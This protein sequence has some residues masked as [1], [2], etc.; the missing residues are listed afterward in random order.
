MD[1]IR[2]PISGCLDI[3]GYGG[4]EEADTLAKDGPVKTP[5]AR[6]LVSALL[7]AKKLSGVT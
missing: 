2:S 4:N 3:R 6:S 5:L 7:W 1:L